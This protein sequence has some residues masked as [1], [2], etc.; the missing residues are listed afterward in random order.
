MFF[1]PMPILLVK[2]AGISV[3]GIWN[4]L[5]SFFPNFVLSLAFVVNKRRVSWS[6]LNLSVNDFHISSFLDPTPDAGTLIP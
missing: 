1:I 6:R 5:S 2:S 3:A 4:P